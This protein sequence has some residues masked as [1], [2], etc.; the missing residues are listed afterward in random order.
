MVAFRNHKAVFGWV[1]AAIF[2]LFAGAMTYVFFRDG[3]PAGYSQL[4]IAAL[5]AL[6]WL[7]ALAGFGFAA[8]QPCVTV[9][10]FPARDVRV[11]HRYLFRRAERLVPRAEIEPAQVV[12]SRDDDGDPYFYARA[13]LGDG[14]RIDLAEG[15][16]R[17]SCDSICRRFNAILSIGPPDA[18]GSRS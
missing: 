18:P 5:L 6:F 11:A 17:E 3:P 14:L 10:V 16:D 9:S 15:H 2:V 8:S 13:T 4:L 7:F 1:F 12:E